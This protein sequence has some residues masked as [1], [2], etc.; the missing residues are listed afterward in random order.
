[1]PSGRVLR[2]ATGLS[3]PKPS[4][5]ER[6]ENN[7]GNALQG[8]GVDDGARRFARRATRVLDDLTPIGN[9]T[10]ADDAQR[11]IRRGNWLQGTLEGS[12]AIL[13][14]PGVAKRVASSGMKKALGGMPGNKV[15]AIPGERRL[16]INPD[17]GPSE[18]FQP[19]GQVAN[20]LGMSIPQPW[21]RAEK[22]RAE[23]KRRGL[24]VG[25]VQQSTNRNGGHSAY[26]KS[27]F[28]ELRFSDHETNMAFRP[29][30]IDVYTDDAEEFLAQAA[31]NK[32]QAL[33]KRSELKKGQELFEREAR[34]RF[35]A[36]SDEGE[37]LRIITS[38]FPW[39]GNDKAARKEI[40]NRW[41]GK[42]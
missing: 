4:L 22:L 23:L 3:A 42:N 40:R 18:A 21:Q 36:T 10:L 38:L 7:L 35:L 14:V 34:E 39:S 29:G 12:L 8:I 19:T 32:E 6:I 1:M 33:V 30:Q 24:D 41:L 27:Q 25:D 9:A 13:P 37:R 28:G 11:S 15:G 20:T 17:H 2:K 26:L 31:Q 5:R 16:A